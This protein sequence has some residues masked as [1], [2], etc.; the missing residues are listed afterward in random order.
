M[1]YSSEVANILTDQLAKFATLNRH[2]L[3]GHVANLDFWAAEVRHGLDVIDGYE[4]RF[5]RLKGAQT[6]YVAEHGTTEFDLRDP[7]CTRRP[8]APPRRVPHADLREARRLLCDAAYRFLARCFQEGL[9]EEATL[10]RTCDSL[11]IGIEP[12]DLKRRS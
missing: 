7:C 3:V 9:V 6:R 8:A 1:S 10:R 4:P 12:T 5:E 2:Q 11:G